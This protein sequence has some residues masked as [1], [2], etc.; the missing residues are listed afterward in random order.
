M[1][2]RR[3][4]EE[5]DRHTATAVPE[6]SHSV[7]VASEFFDIPLDPLQGGDLVSAFEVAGVV[8]VSRDVEAGW[9]RLDQ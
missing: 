5:V 6:Y 2:H 7:R 8:A 3:H 4:D 9:K 1:G